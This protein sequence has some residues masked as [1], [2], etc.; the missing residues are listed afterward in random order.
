MDLKGKVVT[1]DALNTQKE[2]VEAVIRGKGN[3]V[4]ALKGNHSLFYKELQ[5]YFS[6]E[7]LEVL[8]KTPGYYKKTVEKGH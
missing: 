5:E 3:Y 1:W 6:E 7:I 2:T 8:E 4:A